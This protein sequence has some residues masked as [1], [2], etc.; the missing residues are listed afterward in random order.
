MPRALIFVRAGNKPPGILPKEQIM[1]IIP[2]SHT[3][4][5]IRTG[6]TFSF[7]GNTLK[8]NDVK[9]HKVEGVLKGV[10]ITY[11]DKK[12]GTDTCNVSPTKGCNIY[13]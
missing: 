5:Q 1:C 11:T 12:Y 2:L 10:L 3:A 13:R 9:W 7:G 6:D 8:A 4:K